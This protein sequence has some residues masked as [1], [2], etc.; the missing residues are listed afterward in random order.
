MNNIP[1]SICPDKKEDDMKCIANVVLKKM[2]KEFPP[3]QPPQNNTGGN[4]L[5][6]KSLRLELNPFR[7]TSKGGISTNF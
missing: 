4:T 2:E 1:P 3:P 7:G 5:T 6:G